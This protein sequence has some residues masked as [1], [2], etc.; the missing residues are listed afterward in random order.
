MRKAFRAKNRFAIINGSME[1]ID[2][3][4]LN[5]A[6]WER[7]NHFVHSWLIN[8]VS[9]SITQTV[10]FHENFIGVFDA[11][12]KIPLKGKRAEHTRSSEIEYHINRVATK[13][14]FIPQKEER[15]KY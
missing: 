12:R 5:R 8:Y 1:I 15:E 9:N 11:A 2:F 10:I 6:A 3:H 4:D 7:C 13:P 14:L